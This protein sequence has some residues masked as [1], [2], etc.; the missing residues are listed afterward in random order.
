M[1]D[2]QPLPPERLAHR[3]DPAAFDFDTTAAL[4]ARDLAFGQARALDAVGLA[5]DIE[6]RGFNAFVLGE[7][8]SSRHDTVRQLLEAHAA[9]R[10]PA[11]DWCYVNNFSD[12]NKPRALGLPAGTGARFQAA[13]ERFVAELGKAIAAGLDS[14]QYRSRIE[15]I[16]TERKAQEERRFVEIGE[17]AQAEGVALLRTPQGFAFSPLKDGQPLAPPEFEA[18]PEPE[19]DR[20][21]QAVERLRERVDKT[22]RELTRQRRDL[23][24]RVRDATREAMAVAVGHMIDELKEQ[25]SGLPAVLGFLDEVLADVIESGAQLQEQ[26]ADD[27]SLIGVSGTFSVSRYRVN[28]LVGHEAGAHAPVV[29]IDNPT[30]ANLVGRVDHLAHMGT[31]LTNLMLVKPGALHRANGGYLMLDAVKVLAQPLAWDGLKRALAAGEVR[32]ESLPQLLGWMSTL[33]LEPQPIPLSIKIVLFGEREH[34]YLLQALDPEFDDLFKIAADFEDEVP[35]EAGSVAQFA[36]LMGEIAR[37]QGSCPLDRHAVAALV[38]HAS[39]MA[40]DAR[41]LSTRT[42]ELADVVREAGRGCTRAGRAAMARD[43]VKQALAA[44]VRRA[45]RLRD[46]MHEAVQ[47]GTLLIAT[48]GEHVGQVNGLAVNELGAFRFGHPVRITATARVG[49]GHLVDIER[50]S[51]LGQPIHSKGV[52]ILASFLGA[53]YAQGL[54]LSLSA[55][56]V[57]EQSYGPVEGDS[58]SLAELCALLSTLAGVPIRQSLAV[59]GS[60]NQHGRVQAVGAVNEKIEGFFDVCR[61]RGLESGQG[62]IIPAVNVDHL[63]LRDDVVE[64]A[65]QGRFHVYAVDDV[66]D[67]IELLTGIAAGKPDSTGRLPEGSINR[68]VAEKLAHMSEVRLA[69]RERVLLR[70]VMREPRKLP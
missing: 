36:A 18:L 63:M 59:T 43:D 29:S 27:E 25:F 21:T 67:A 38:E 41:K 65:A 58:A 33:P 55:S 44:R 10:P 1:A 12:P 6:G 23:H 53:R 11:E 32:I 68:R 35:R 39:R 22:T 20:I 34:Y 47:R 5:L 48:S 15:A 56:L 54:P 46:A 64:A 70:D 3:C 52:M 37:A 50:E 42:R 8:G 61:L 40:G 24:V 49:D 30:Y 19:R 57:F 28:L 51:T 26:R 66:D 13:M 14:E 7:P 69:F 17:A 16:E 2:L 4:S 9:R 45:D 60:V 62:V 31:L